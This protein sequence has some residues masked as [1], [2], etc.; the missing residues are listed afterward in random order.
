MVV[1]KHGGGCASGTETLNLK[2]VI[3]GG[4]CATVNGNVSASMMSGVETMKKTEAV[5]VPL[6]AREVGRRW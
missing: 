1:V 2:E 3:H 5:K 4:G 6:K